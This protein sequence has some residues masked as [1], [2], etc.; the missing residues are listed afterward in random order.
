MSGG[1]PVT[2]AD[3]V[4]EF[5]SRVVANIVQLSAGQWHAGTPPYPNADHVGAQAEPGNKTETDI[6][7]TNLVPTSVFNI[8][9]GWAMEMTR[10]RRVRALRLRTSNTSNPQWS[11]TNEQ[12]GGVGNTPYTSMSEDFIRYFPIPGGQP[13]GGTPMNWTELQNFM[14]TLKDRVNDIRNSLVTL[15]GCHSSCHGNCHSS[16]SRR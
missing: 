12:L 6:T 9:H 7:V 10:M 15:Q 11:V 8:L 1:S 14:D 13:N 4:N 16:R 2:K 5:N 3:I